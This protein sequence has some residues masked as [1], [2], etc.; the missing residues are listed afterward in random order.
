MYKKST[1]YKWL[2]WGSL[3]PAYLIVHF[4]RWSLGIVKDNLTDTFNLSAVAFANL[5]SMYF[6]AYML[7]Q[8]PTGML[9]DSLGVRFTATMGMLLAGAGSLLFG[10]SPNT[11]VVFVGR[12]L[13]G[14]GVSVIFISI[15][16]TLSKWYN[17]REF[18]TMTGLTSFIGN[19]GG[20][21]AQSPFVLLLSLFTWQYAFISIGI[22]SILAALLCFSL[23]R[24]KPED[25]GLPSEL[26]N[27]EMDNEAE[28]TD[29][30]KALIEILKNPYTWPSFIMYAGFYGAYQSIAGTWGQGFIMEVYGMDKITAA[31]YMLLMFV[32]LAAGCFIIGK[33]SDTLTKRKVPMMIFGAMYL[34][35][36]T[37]L[38]FIN[39]GKPPVEILGTL[40]VI[41][42]FSESTITLSWACGMEV[43]N[44]RYTGVSTSVI[45]IGGFFGAAVEPLILGLVMDRYGN[46]LSSQQLYY[47]SFLI[48]LASVAVG[49]ICILLIKETSC[50]NIVR[51]DSNTKS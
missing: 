3:I 18:A 26:K 40:L 16:K 43:N 21:L 19:T 25:L 41:I 44:P 5:G 14:I 31:N 13:I 15:L 47:K 45:N 29:V 7:M 27:K 50:K 11:T 24:N 8:L 39:K 46:V 9:V 1:G 35:S 23:V 49:F 51:A 38:V 48:C 30:F 37:L 33:L 17:E 12:F 2:V 28:K 32:G 20:I 34:A 42:G 4:H 6:Y 22:L 36:W 10:Y